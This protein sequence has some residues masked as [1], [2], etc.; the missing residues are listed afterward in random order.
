MPLD[1]LRKGKRVTI[2][3]PIDGTE[4]FGEL[5]VSARSRPAPAPRGP[6]G[7]CAVASA[8][9]SK[10]ISTENQLQGGSVHILLMEETYVVIFGRQGG[11][12][13]GCNGRLFTATTGGAFWSRGNPAARDCR[14]AI[15]ARLVFVQPLQLN[16]FVVF[17][18]FYFLC[19]S[20]ILTPSFIP[21]RSLLHTRLRP[22]RI[23]RLKRL[24]NG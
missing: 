15:T 7:L 16:Q 12:G 2:P 19:F 20:S 9:R 13:D 4:P 24:S 11:H 6:A 18:G 23:W 14:G 1:K 22:S 8:R 3:I 10:T 5:P 21:F 17:G